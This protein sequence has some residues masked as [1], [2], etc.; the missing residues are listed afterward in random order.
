MGKRIGTE[1]G[2]SHTLSH[3]Y[4]I[5]ESPRI[6]ASEVDH[7]MRLPVATVLIQAAPFF[8]QTGSLR[9][10]SKLLFIRTIMHVYV[11]AIGSL[12]QKKK[13]TSDG[14][15]LHDCAT[16]QHHMHTACWNK[17]TGVY[18]NVPGVHCMYKHAFECMCC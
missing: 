14:I 13:K 7:H 9:R 5:I 11:T 4:S 16:L 18:L 12:L 17:S 15:H 8:F 2:H 6:Q 10:Y 1:E 3:K